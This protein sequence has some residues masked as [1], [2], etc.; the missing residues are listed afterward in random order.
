MSTTY[1]AKPIKV[2]AFVYG[3]NESAP[4]WF[5]TALRKRQIHIL[6]SPGHIVVK[7][8]AGKI[9]FYDP[10]T[11]HAL[12]ETEES[13]KDLNKDGEVDTREEAIATETK[14]KKAKAKAS[15]RASSVE[16][17]ETKPKA[18]KTTKPKTKEEPVDEA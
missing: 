11:F 18:K 6:P 8:E 12:F 15:P 2:E 1:I 17:S 16:P 3:G 10:T 5:L 4:L 13:A 9:N 14:N 7:T